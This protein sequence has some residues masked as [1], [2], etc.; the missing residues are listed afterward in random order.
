MYLAAHLT[1][2]HK[3]E[4]I[5]MVYCCCLPLSIP[6]NG[7]LN[8][9]ACSVASYNAKLWVHDPQYHNYFALELFHNKTPSASVSYYCGL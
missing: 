2:C 4:N 3:S 9:F 5:R 1:C 7:F 8:H 6:S